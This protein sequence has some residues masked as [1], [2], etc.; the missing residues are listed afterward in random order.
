MAMPLTKRN[1]KPCRGDVAPLKGSA[2]KEMAAELSEKWNVVDEHH[3]TRT[4]KFKNWQD[5]VAFTVRIAALA[6]KENHHPDIFLSY[7]KVE[8]TV[9][10]HKIG[11]LSPNDFILAAKI[12]Q[13]SNQA[14]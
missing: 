5:A 3:L 2:L 10:T 6:E 11:G 13:A 7:G 4:Y 9:F 1:C 12:E 14:T 8:V